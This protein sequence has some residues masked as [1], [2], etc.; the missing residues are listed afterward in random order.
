MVIA[1]LGDVFY[2]ALSVDLEQDIILGKY[3]R[4]RQGNTEKVIY[5]EKERKKKKKK[6]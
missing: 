5:K 4:I 1:E 3:I 6:E 2:A